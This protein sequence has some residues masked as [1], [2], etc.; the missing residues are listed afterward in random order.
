MRPVYVRC[1]RRASGTTQAIDGLHV[2]APLRPPLWPQP[3]THLLP[4][5]EEH[6]PHFEPVIKLTEQVETSTGE[7]DEDVL[8]KM[9]VP[10]L[11]VFA[12]YPIV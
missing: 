4:Q 6:D 9:C 2:L 8:F 12:G 1:P 10:F 3:L 7:E 5:D 11:A